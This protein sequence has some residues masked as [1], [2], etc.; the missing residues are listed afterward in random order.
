MVDWSI[1]SNS[2]LPPPSEEFFEQTWGGIKHFLNEN[3]AALKIDQ[4]W[5]GSRELDGIGIL[6][7]KVK[8]TSEKQSK[9][10]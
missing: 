4:T 3:R 1:P 2:R 6:N 5:G 9:I 8:F 7:R 10:K